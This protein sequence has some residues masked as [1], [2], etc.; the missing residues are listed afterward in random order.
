MAA[1]SRIWDFPKTIVSIHKFLS[2]FV[3]MYFLYVATFSKGMPFSGVVN[4]F[5]KFI[6]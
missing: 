6:D 2:F 3:G 4:H 1:K 5:R